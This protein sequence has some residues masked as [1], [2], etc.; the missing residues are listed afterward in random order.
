MEAI[1]HNVE[2]ELGVANFITLRR[3]YDVLMGIYSN[4]NEEEAGKLAGLH[5]QGIFITPPPAWRPGS[6]GDDENGEV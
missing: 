6:D 5:Q 4:I 1:E 3:I 2:D